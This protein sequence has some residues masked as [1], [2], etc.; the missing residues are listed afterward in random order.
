M[1]WLFVVPLI[2]SW[3]Y[4][5]WIHRNRVF[6]AR[7][8]VACLWSDVVSG[9]IIAVGIRNKT[10]FFHRMR[11]ECFCAHYEALSLLQVRAHPEVRLYIS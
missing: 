7:L 11:S 2:T 9:L 8:T 6:A 3:H 5:I 10:P 4:R 1:L